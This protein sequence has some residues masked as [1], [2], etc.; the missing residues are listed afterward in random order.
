MNVYDQIQSLDLGTE[1]TV[2]LRGTVRDWKGLHVFEIGDFHR[3]AVSLKHAE[4]IT[5]HEPVIKWQIGDVVRGPYGVTFVRDEDGGWRAPSG[6]SVPVT[7]KS[8]HTYAPV[9]REGKI[10]APPALDD[11]RGSGQ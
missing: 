8:A 2:T 10:V 4:S 5:V 11:S 1:V 3:L 9:I 7:D 6:K